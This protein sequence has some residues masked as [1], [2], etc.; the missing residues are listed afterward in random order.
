MTMRY[1]MLIYTRETETASAEEM[2][3][4]SAAHWAI[5]DET[6]RR[7]ILR[8]TDPLGPQQRQPLSGCKTGKLW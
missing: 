7:G 5:M 8:A 4:V 2:E 6:A 3:A 1:M